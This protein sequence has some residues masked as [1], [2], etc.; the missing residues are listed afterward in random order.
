MA[1]KFGT[2]LSPKE[3][4]PKKIFARSGKKEEEKCCG[5]YNY[6]EVRIAKYH[7]LLK[8]YF[9]IV[10]IYNMQIIQ[11]L[12]E[13]SRWLVSDGKQKLGSQVLK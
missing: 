12:F 1:T 10:F 7:H 3:K 5:T 8:L 11:K 9:S 6:N 2:F 13:D 4:K